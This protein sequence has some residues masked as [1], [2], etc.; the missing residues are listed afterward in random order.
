MGQGT[1]MRLAGRPGASRG[2]SAFPQLRAVGL[3]ESGT[4]G[5]F[6]VNVGPYDQG[7]ITL[8]ETLTARLRAGM[9]CLADRNFLGYPLWQQARSTGAD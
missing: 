5:I 9:L 3:V 6:G 7:E 4:H 8:A 2:Q 1:R